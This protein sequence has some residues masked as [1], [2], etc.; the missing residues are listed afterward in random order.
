MLYAGGDV[1]NSVVAYTFTSSVF[2]IAMY[3]IF[4]WLVISFILLNV[5][6]RALDALKR[7]ELPSRL[8]LVMAVL[9][10]TCLLIVNTTKV[11]ECIHL[12]ACECSAKIDGLRLA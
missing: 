1:A 9:L 10:C 8:P 2:D 3:S 4:K 5:E 11:S 6:N 12:I 7:K